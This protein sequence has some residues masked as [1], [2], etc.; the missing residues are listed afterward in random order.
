MTIADRQPRIPMTDGFE[1]VRRAVVIGAGTMGSGIAAHLANCGIVVA[2]LDRVADGDD[3]SALARTAIERQVQVG[4]FMV[5]AF[6][7]RVTPGNVEDDLD[8]VAEADWIVEAVFEDPN[9]KHELY[10]KLEGLRRPGTLVSSNT[11]GIPVAEL[12]RGHSEEF[13]RDFTITHFFNPPRTMELL[14]VVAGSDTSP[15]VLERTIRVADRQ[16]GKTVLECRDTPGFIANRLGSHWMAVAALEAFEAGLDVETADAIMSRPFGI[17]RTGV[18]GL[19]D[20]V[21]VNLVPLLWPVLTRALPAD[22]AAQRYDLMGDRVFQHLLDNGLIGRRGPGGF[23]R[24]KNE[25]G[26]MVDEVI[27]LE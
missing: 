19:F 7:A 27:D 15:E 14:E 13:A 6:A 23:T 12:V 4:G 2:L 26:E 9:V 1:P 5:P 21:G 22:D 16:L 3:R 8:V 18:F 17:P 25:A 11:S 24:R 10:A 20:L